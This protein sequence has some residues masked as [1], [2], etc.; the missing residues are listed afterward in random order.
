M[1]LA[2]I[3]ANETYVIDGCN[4]DQFYQEEKKIFAKIFAVMHLCQKLDK[5]ELKFE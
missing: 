5:Q 1:F 4:Q 2:P 3:C